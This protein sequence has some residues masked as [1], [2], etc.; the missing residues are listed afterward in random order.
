[1]ISKKKINNRVNRFLE[2]TSIGNREWVFSDQDTSNEIHELLEESLDLMEEMKFGSAKAKLKRLLKLK[3]DHI[4]AI[5]HLAIIENR[6][7]NKD[8]SRK[9]WER[10]VEIGR[11]AIPKSFKRGSSRIPWSNLDNRPFLR[12]LHGHAFALHEDGKNDE[13]LEVFRELI[14]YNPD[15]NQRVRDILMEMYLEE[16]RYAD[17][18]ELADSFEDDA[19]PEIMYGRILVLLMRG[20]YE[21][22]EKELEEAV[23]FNPKVAE[24]LLKEDHSKPEG[25]MPGYIRPGDWDEAYVYWIS[26]GKYWT[27]D[28]IEWLR[29]KYQEISC[30]DEYDDDDLFEMNEPCKML[31]MGEP[32]KEDFE[33]E[34]EFQ[35]LLEVAMGL[36][37]S[38]I[39]IKNRSI[40]ILADVGVKAI[41][42]VLYAVE[43]DAAYDDESPEVYKSFNNA[44]FEV[45][46]RIGE[47]AV[48]ILERYIIDEDVDEMVNVFAQEAIFDV[49][50][51]D[52]E[53]RKKIC[54]HIKAIPHEETGK[55]FYTCNICEK[56]LTE[57]EWDE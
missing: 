15:D 7:K 39:E 16:D 14:D 45:M 26:Q 29:E 19:S 55:R 22:A 23:R 42:P 9:L 8:S 33:S 46:R 21:E 34:R 17:A 56:V 13:A 38:T 28:D 47:P 32:Y 37:S 3:P 43:C 11:S 4:D 51:L 41:G 36:K 54:K 52:E 2:L 10:G 24:E 57:E 48:P 53:E 27:T 50:G 30:E 31:D 35:D 25:W 49:L 6:K 5:H 18:M 44:Y 1:M 20:S 12:C 40:D